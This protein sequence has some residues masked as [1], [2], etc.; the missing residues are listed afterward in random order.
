MIKRS[1]PGQDGFPSCSFQIFEG[2]ANH[3]FCTNGQR[4]LV[5]EVIRINVLMIL[6]FL[7]VSCATNQH[8]KSER[9]AVHPNMTKDE[10]RSSMGAP[11]TVQF[12]DGYEQWVYYE[13]AMSG[14]AAK[15]YI[16][17]F[18]GEFV[19]E[20]YESTMNIQP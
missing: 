8:P 5:S 7:M 12:E 3:G 17:Y 1:P 14:S 18:S 16:I 4:A 10:V 2:R 19:L 9:F 15:I 13:P 20:I 6:F 11:R